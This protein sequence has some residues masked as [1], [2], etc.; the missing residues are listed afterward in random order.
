MNVLVLGL[1]SVLMGDDA[2]GPWAMRLLEAGYTFPP[3]VT[4]MDAGTPGPELAHYVAGLDAL[5]VLDSVRHSRHPAGTVV[6]LRDEA[7]RRGLP[8]PRLSP[9]DPNLCD[10]LLAC[11]LL[12]GGP[13]RKM[14]LFG[15]VPESVELRTSLTPAVAAALPRLVQAVVDELTALGV[16]PVA[17]AEAVAPDVWWERAAG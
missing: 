4:L 15:V 16:A 7:M 8:A 10:A 9:H 12:P 3:E 13:P 6:E 1:G 14:T 5:V 11:E 2:V 17:V